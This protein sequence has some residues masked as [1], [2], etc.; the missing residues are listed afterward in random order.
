MHR[1]LSRRT[2][3]SRRSNG[4]CASSR[5]ALDSTGTTR[6]TLFGLMGND[7]LSFRELFK[8][9]AEAA[10][11]S[12]RRDEALKLQKDLTE[13]QIS[14]AINYMVNQSGGNFK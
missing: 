1:L 8:L 4:A 5:A 10:K 7:K 6:G 14:A 9:E 3:G 11:E 13:A 12:K 2:A